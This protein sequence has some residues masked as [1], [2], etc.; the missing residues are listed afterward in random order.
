MAP[1]PV[2]T[3]HRADAQADKNAAINSANN[4]SDWQQIYK[5]ELADAKLGLDDSQADADLA[6]VKS[7]AQ[8]NQSFQ[9]TDATDWQSMIDGQA[10]AA[11]QFA[12]QNDATTQTEADAGAQAAAATMVPRAQAEQAQSGGDAAAAASFR[13]AQAN[14]TA[15]I[16]NWLAGQLGN[17]PWARS[18]AG[19]AG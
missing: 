19:L 5:Q 7:V 13:I 2:G 8:V 6:W 4:V 3:A 10:Q 15:T 14:E 9:T 16:W 18:Q 11:D 12:H 17:T 1:P